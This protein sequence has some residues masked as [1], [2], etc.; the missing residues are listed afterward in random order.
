MKTVITEINEFF[1]LSGLITEQATLFKQLFSKIGVDDVIKAARPNVDDVAKNRIRNLMSDIASISGDDLFFIIKNLEPEKTAKLFFDNGLIFSKNSLKNTYD[2]LIPRIKSGE[3][4][5]DEVIESWNKS[6][7]ENFF[8]RVSGDVDDELIKIADAY[9]DNL[10]DDFASYAKIKNPK[11]KIPNASKIL[12]KLN[13]SPFFK[14]APESLKSGFKAG[15]RQKGVARLYWDALTFPINIAGDLFTLSLGRM[16]KRITSKESQRFH[17]WL[18]SGVPKAPKDILQILK[19]EGLLPLAAE[20][21]GAS[22]RR[23][24][25]VSAFLT[26][27][28]A[29][30]NV[31]L[32]RIGEKEKEYM[33][34]RNALLL[35]LVRLRDNPKYAKLT[36]IFPYKIFW[37]YIIPSINIPLSDILSSRGLSLKTIDALKHKFGLV[38]VENLPESLIKAAG[39]LVGDIDYENGNY[40]LGYER[41][42][43]KSYQKTWVVKINGQ[44]YKLSEIEKK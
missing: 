30:Y 20:T 26:G 37:N 27:V 33:D 38:D 8:G 34:D 19:K 15:L 43:I 23:F 41:L 6:G 4:T 44:W 40:F 14:T 42:P 11:I 7:R 32:E 9:V 17:M 10:S 3:I 35:F 28:N 24:L 31:Y 13:K 39:T 22:V 1:M 2:N 25:V 16:F 18:A 12:S 29:I 5:F 36:H 21:V